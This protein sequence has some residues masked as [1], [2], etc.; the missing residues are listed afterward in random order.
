LENRAA[1]NLGLG[2]IKIRADLVALKHVVIWYIAPAEIEIFRHFV[3]C[4]IKSLPNFGIVPLFK[5]GSDCAIFYDFA[6]FFKVRLIFSGSIFLNGNLKE[7]GS[8][9]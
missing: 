4:S 9:E 3:E 5:K 2:F 1:H 8:I 6:Y 7:N